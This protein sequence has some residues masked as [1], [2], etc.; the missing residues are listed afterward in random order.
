MTTTMFIILVFVAIF[1][2]IIG[3]EISNRIKLR[4]LVQ[5]KWG[6]QP[7]QPRFDK[8]TS[9]KEAWKAASAYQKFTSEVDDITWYDLDMF[10][11]FE[12]I[13]ATYSST[14]SEALYQ[15]LRNY[16]FDNK[17]NQTMEKLIQFYQEQ[18]KIRED[19][20]FHFARLGKKDNNFV[21]QY[22][23]DAQSK[24]IAN[25]WLYICLGLLPFVGFGIAFVQPMVGILTIIG[26]ICF[27][28][29]YYLIKKQTLDTELN[30]MS[31]L[32][33]TISA[34]NAIVKLDSPL[35]KELMEYL[36]PL[37]SI[38][39]F[40]FSFRVKVGSEAEMLF[41]YINIMFMLPFISYHYVLNHLEKNQ[42]K[43]KK[44][45]DILGQYEVA[46]AVL[47]FRTYMPI[48]CQPNFA[49]GGVVSEGIYHPLLS[50]AVMNDVDWQDNTLVTGSNASGKSTYV[51]SVAIS[52]IL[53]QTIQTA[54]AE[55]FTLQEGHVL[56]SMAVE[57]DIFEGDSYFVAEI[58][59]IK[60][61]LDKAKTEER[62]YCFVDEILKGT[63]TIERI[64]ASASVVD[65]LSDYPSIAFVATHDIELTEI[66]KN[67]C[68]NVHFEEQVTKEHG[69]TFD[70]KLRQ[71]PSKTR[72]AI[73]LLKVMNYPKEVVAKAKEEAEG[74]DAT[75][76][77]QVL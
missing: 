13:N 57:D 19:I 69:I 24:Q 58:K 37:K 44:L 2:A 4:K 6:K 14:G 53:A 9:L 31:Y 68:K 42:G 43:A 21:K 51:K 46:A 18:P 60:R 56:T 55:N 30:S 71:G 33:Q 48:T 36:A 17:D 72:N 64:S 61:V 22:L 27:N 40:G 54:V 66:L 45:W 16:N 5:M 34:A 32:V 50:K 20:Q 76:Q 25:Q 8:E 70:Y 74:F 49:K 23:S 38:P 15:R 11:V 67:S 41:D 39:K 62:C 10:A 59:S 35:K 65:W 28:T 47:N 7:N 1:V 77:W 75:R 63:N 26:S 52:C 12:L 73:E 3:L 29:V